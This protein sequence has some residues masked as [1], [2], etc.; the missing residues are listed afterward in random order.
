[1]SCS[2]HPEHGRPRRQALSSGTNAPGAS[3]LSALG[4]PSAADPLL[5]AAPRPGERS[6]R[7]AHGCRRTPEPSHPPTHPPSH[8]G[9][10]GPRA[11]PDSP[12]SAAAARALGPRGESW[13]GRGGAE[14]AAAPQSPHGGLHRVPAT[15]TTRPAAESSAPGARL[16]SPV[17]TRGAGGPAAQ[18]SREV[19]GLRARRSSSCCCGGGGCCGCGRASGAGH[20]PGTR[21]RSG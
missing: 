12:G 15:T 6:S 20:A 1:M 4:L 19:R 2:L 5:P 10:G 14:P 18:V 9:P 8:P 17:R 3:P 11:D 16:L 7:A 21:W 13:S